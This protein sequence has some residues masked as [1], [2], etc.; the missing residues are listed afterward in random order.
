MSHTLSSANLIRSLHF[1]GHSVSSSSLNTILEDL[2]SFD[3]K[4]SDFKMIE[5][6]VSEDFEFILKP[7]EV[8]DSFKKLF[9]KD[10]TGFITVEELRSALMRGEVDAFNEEE[11]EEV[12]KCIGQVAEDKINYE[13]FV[14][15]FTQERS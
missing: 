8:R 9:D 1:L 2:S 4:F 11:F 15:E 3:I 6:K 13:S 10:E 7:E 12:L 5:K 14:R